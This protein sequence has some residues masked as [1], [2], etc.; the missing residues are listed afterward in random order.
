MIRYRLY[1][2]RL[3]ERIKKAFDA[4]C[5]SANKQLNLCEEVEFDVSIVSAQ[6]IKTIN[7]KYRKIN[8]VTDVISFANRD[9]KEIFVPLIGEIFICLEQA[10]KQAKLYKHT[11][12]REMMFLFT[13]GLLHLLGFDH[14]TKKDKKVMF[15]ITKKIIIHAQNI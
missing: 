11:L 6:N 1:G 10:K 9:R 2:K 15:D 7:K 14:Q 4:I 8:K 12:E 13:H 3:P 5:V